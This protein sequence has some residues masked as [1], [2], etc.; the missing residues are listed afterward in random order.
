MNY[1]HIFNTQYIQ[2]TSSIFSLL[3]LFYKKDRFK[4]Q[5]C[6]Y[7]HQPCAHLTIIT[8]ETITHFHQACV[9]IIPWE[10]SLYFLSPVNN[11]TNIQNEWAFSILSTR[12]WTK[13]KNPVILTVIHHGQNPSE[14]NNT[15]MLAMW[16][17][18]DILPP[19]AGSWNFVY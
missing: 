18:K 7:I 16:E 11:N 3:S 6:T 9:D 12:R 5:W 15:N 2:M 13:S 1:M 4:V 14:S 19:Q 8:L 10:A 17:G